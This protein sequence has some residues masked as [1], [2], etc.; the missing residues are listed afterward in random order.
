MCQHVISSLNDKHF[1]KKNQLS[2]TKYRIIV[3][4]YKKKEMKWFMPPLQFK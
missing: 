4:R 1:E 3:S 2:R